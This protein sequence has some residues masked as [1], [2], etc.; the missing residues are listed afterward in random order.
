MEIESSALMREIES[1]IYADRK[2]NTYVWRLEIHANEETYEPLKIISIDVPAN[3]ERN[4]GDEVIVE[5]AL[6]GGMY[7]KRIFPFQNN[8]DITLYKIPVHPV[9]GTVDEEEA[10]ESERYTAILLNKENPLLEQ[11]GNNSPTED[12]LD[13]TNIFNIKFQLINKAL[14]R[15]RLISVGGIYRDVTTEDVIKAILTKESKELGIEKG[16]TPIGVDMVEGSNQTKRTHI[17]IPQGTR[18]VDMPEY[19]HVKCG[20]VYNAGLSCYFQNDFWYIYPTYNTDRFNESQRTLTIINVPA[21]KFPG[22]EATYK[23]E[24]D[25]LTILATGEVQF[26]DDT[27]GMQLNHGNGVRFSDASR[28]IENFVKV[29]N[30]KAIVSR[31]D[32]NTELI[33]EERK[34]GLNNVVKSTNS[35]TANPFVEYS[36]LAVRQG[37]ILSFVWENSNP[38]LMFPGMVAK[39]MYLE[40]EEIKE[41]Y[42]AILNAHHYTHLKGKGMFTDRHTT[43]TA[44]TLFVKPPVDSEEV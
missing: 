41:V 39:V 34:N 16:R 7:S 40:N 44:I 6:L 23:K 4:Y 26:K 2:P 17:C 31:K 25:A 5:V 11:N 38:S 42:G 13:L 20:G 1:I 33:S 37:G 10:M 18:L 14:E 12:I 30:N 15:L 3:Y 29:E 27:D 32:N 8:L 21:N 35:I 28:F 19:V 22:I 9:T 43:N 24:G 36:K